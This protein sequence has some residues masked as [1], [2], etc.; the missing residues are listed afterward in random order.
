MLVKV[1][2]IITLFISQISFS[3]SY[4]TNSAIYLYDYNEV[5]YQ[6][7]FP[8]GFSQFLNYVMKNYKIPDV[9]GLNGIV[10][11]DFV[12]EKD[13]TLSNIKIITDLGEGTGEEAIR[14][15]LKCPAW[16]PAEKDGKRVRVI[17]HNFLITIKN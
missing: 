14:V 12:I 5:Y 6:P 1:L 4:N 15:L 2:S 9:E 17:F 3:Q 10:K 7:V 11:I 8:G 13:G 16:T